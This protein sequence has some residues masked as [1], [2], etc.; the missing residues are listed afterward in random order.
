MTRALLRVG[1]TTSLTIWEQPVDDRRAI[2]AR[3]FD[4]GIDHVFFADH[5]SFRN[6]GGNDGMIQAAALANLHPT[7]G[8]YAGV[9]LL[10]LRHPVPVARQLCDLALMAPGRVSFGVGVGGDDRHEIEVCGVDPS[11]RG[12][13]TDEA[14]LV[15][16]RLLAG[17]T[18]DHE[19]EFFSLEQAVM[20][21]T[22]A[23]PIPIYVGGRSDAA[24]ERAGRFGRGWLGAWCSPDRFAR[25][26]ETFDEAATAH[27]RT[28]DTDHGLQGWIGVGPSREV[29]RERVSAAM[30]D[31]YRVPFEAF[32]RYTPYGT[33]DDIV[34]ELA[35]YLEAGCRH[36]N[37]TPCAGTDEEAVEAVA[38]IK[39]RL[40]EIDQG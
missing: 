22:P 25:A 27:G 4:G 1:V 30:Y 16:T 9:Y 13:R 32:E 5:V 39:R 2:L 14:L 29:A 23:E 3:A 26:T 17:E 11:S 40:V 15:L 10:A 37:L 7:I 12:R 34:E 19:G 24:I 21:P 36:F 8:V 6:G 33:V 35:P 18:V 20:V 38:E 31:F 28:V